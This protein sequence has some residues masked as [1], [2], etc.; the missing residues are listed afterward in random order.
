MMAGLSATL[1]GVGLQRFAYAPL[2]PA[3][4]QAG[5]LGAGPAGTLGAA[6]FG[7]Y[8]AGALAAPWIG[9]R[10]D[11]RWALRGAMLLATACF[12]LCAVRGSLGWFLPWRTLAGIAGGVL[13]VLAGPAVQASVPSSVRGLVAGVM[14]AGPGTGIVVGAAIVPLLLPAGLPLAWLALAAAGL[15][16]TALSWTRWPNVPAPPRTHRPGL[17]SDTGRLVLLYALSAVAATPHMAWWPDFIVRGLG[18]GTGEGAM[19][20]LLFGAAAAGGPTVCG[21]L[22]DRLGTPRAMLAALLVQEVGVAMPLLSRSMPLLVLSPIL[23][24]ATALGLT[25][26]ALMR[27]RELAGDGAPGV[28]RM[29]TVAWAAAQTASGFGLAWLYAA[30]GSH[31]PLFAFGAAAALVAIWLAR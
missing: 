18:R 8:L 2:L 11:M 6:N 17:Q 20:W 21:R 27:A 4:V 23:S 19:S 16:L 24:G 10:L 22:A 25:G 13:M 26:L 7:G 31:L 5:W 3:M 30:T 9:R 14:F 1:L 12:A 15:L 28:W 29:C